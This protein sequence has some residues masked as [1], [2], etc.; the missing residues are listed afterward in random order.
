[1]SILLN[2]LGIAGLI[3]SITAQAQTADSKLDWATKAV[4]LQQGPE[5]DRL[6]GQLAES[7]AQELVQSWG[8]K[9]SADVPKTQVEK[10]A[11]SLNVELKK[12]HDE[13]SEIIKNKVN[14]ASTDGLIPAYMERFSLDEL[15][16][17]VVFFE[18]SAVKKYQATAPELGNIFINQLIVETRADVFARAKIFDNAATK[19]VSASAREPNIADATVPDKNKPIVKK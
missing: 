4:A 3:F 14:K 16:Q 15:R 12:Y 19:I 6:I 17:L 5:L 11:G 18:S 2:A 10:A 13:V 7:S 1:M 8:A 9:L